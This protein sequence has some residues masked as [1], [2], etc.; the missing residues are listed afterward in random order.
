MRT[1]TI[2]QTVYNYSDLL[3]PENEALKAKVIT[4]FETGD[5]DYIWNDAHQTVKKFNEVLN[6]REG[7][8]SWLDFNPNCSNDAYQYDLTGL[9]L[10]TFVINNF[11]S[12]LYERKLIYKGNNIKKSRVSKLFKNRC[13]V[14]TGVCYDES[15]L[16]PV[17]NL[18]EKYDNSMSELTFEQLIKDCLNTLRKDIDNEIEYNQS[19]VAILETIQANEYEFDSDGNII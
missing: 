7:V 13:C 18:I 17:Y 16:Q 1:L 6:L 4:N 15:I 19:D 5:F 12:D 8:H 11:Y 10:R 3:L 14:L 9:R 2:E